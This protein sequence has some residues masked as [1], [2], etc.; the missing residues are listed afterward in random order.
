MQNMFMIMQ[1]FV[2]RFR[3]YLDE[4]GLDPTTNLRADE[5]DDKVNNIVLCTVRPCASERARH[6]R[7]T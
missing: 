6:F 1:W 7:G 5:Q 4:I 3:D 2:T